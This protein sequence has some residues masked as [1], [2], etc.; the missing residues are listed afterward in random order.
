M[1]LRRGD[2]M[3]PLLALFGGLTIFGVT[4]LV[5]GSGFLAVYLAGI[6][7]GNRSLRAAASIR[8]FHN[9]I[10]WMRS[11]EHTSELQSLM[12]H[13][14]AVFCLKKNNSPNT[15]THVRVT[16][17]QHTPHINL[18]TSFVILCTKSKS[19]TQ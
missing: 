3:Y 17:E 10:A 16:S 11:E 14:Y 5:G 18:H 9:G 1:R 13:S 15:Y 2:S 4:A 6:V 12:R 8:R 7:L 19:L